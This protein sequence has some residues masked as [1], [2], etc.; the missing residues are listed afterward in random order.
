MFGLFRRKQV[1]VQKHWYAPMLDFRISTQEFYKAVEDEL[2]QRQVPTMDASRVEFAEGGWLSAQRQ[3]LRLRREWLVFDICAA[4]FGTS[5]FFSL[6]GSIIQ[7]TL[8][9]W[10]VLLALAGLGSLFCLYWR[11]FGL[12]PGCIAIG[13]SLAALAMFF[14]FAG[15]WQGLDDAIAQL[16]VLGAIYELFFRRE[17]YYREDTRLMYLDI[18]ERIV[19]HQIAEFTAAKG[20]SLLEVKD[21]TPPASGGLLDLATKVLSAAR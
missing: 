17:T 3:Y 16:P 14:Y 15:R 5:W 9:L 19:Q 20:V 7:R 18:I 4:P 8:H 11:M 1:I 2:S 10:E 13:V 6:R 21:V 12:V